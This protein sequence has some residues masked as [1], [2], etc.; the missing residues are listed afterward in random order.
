MSRNYVRKVVRKLKCSGRKRKEIKRQLTAELLAESPQGE[1]FGQITERMGRP[2]ELAEE[3]NSNFT[4]EEKKKYRR[5]TW[6]KRIGILLAVVVLLGG[7]IFWYLPK[8]TAIENS[9]VFQKELLQETAK[10]VIQL[11]DDENYPE[12]KE[13]SAEALQKVLN[14]QVMDQAR[15][16][17]GPDWGAFRSFGNAYISENSQMGKRSAAVQINAAYENANVTYAIVFDEDMMVEG[18]WMK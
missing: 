5:E 15:A 8:T 2:E 6:T 13:M 10:K 17:I 11:L 12:L 1:T 3:F 9:K 4:P 14:E 18:L 16:A 7:V